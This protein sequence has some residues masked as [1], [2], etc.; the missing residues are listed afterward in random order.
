M[1]IKPETGDGSLAQFISLV[2]SHDT[3]EVVVLWRCRFDCIMC[4]MGGFSLVG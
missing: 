1:K 4:F 2:V 3:T